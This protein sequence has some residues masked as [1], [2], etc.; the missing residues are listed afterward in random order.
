[1]WKYGNME[2][3]KCENALGRSIESIFTFPHFHICIFPTF[4]TFPKQPFIKLT[5]LRYRA[6]TGSLAYVAQYVGIN[7]KL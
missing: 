6:L 4:L 5:V 7:D 2:I 1:M 3:W